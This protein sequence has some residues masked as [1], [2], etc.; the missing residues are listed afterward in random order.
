MYKYSKYTVN[1]HARSS[2]IENTFSKVPVWKLF[3]PYPPIQRPIFQPSRW[4]FFAVRSTVL[5]P[6]QIQLSAFQAL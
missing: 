2:M 6:N 3:C 5:E 4:L 1:A